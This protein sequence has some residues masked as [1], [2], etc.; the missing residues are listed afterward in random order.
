MDRLRE[1][2]K[3]MKFARR[4][5]DSR[6]DSRGE[7]HTREAVEYIAMSDELNKAKENV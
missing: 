4:V 7:Q 3:R 1:E 5:F 6:I 2:L